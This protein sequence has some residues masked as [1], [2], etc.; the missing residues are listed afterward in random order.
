[1]RGHRDACSRR[2]ES[3][4]YGQQHSRQSQNSTMGVKSVD[5]RGPGCPE[6]SS[7][8]RRQIHDDGRCDWEK[9]RLDIEFCS[10]GNNRRS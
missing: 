2:A 9:H 5:R 6:G 3:R 8:D 10:V 7:P 4:I 1:M